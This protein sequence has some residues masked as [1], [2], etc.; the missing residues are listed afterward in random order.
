MSKL[1]A[2]SPEVK[3]AIL[4]V[5]ARWSSLSGWRA[6]DEEKQR[7]LI[8]ALRRYCDSA[9]DIL[10]CL[11]YFYGASQ[12][13]PTPNEIREAK[14]ERKWGMVGA[15][16]LAKL[17]A[18]ACKSC[19]E[20]EGSGKRFG[21]RTVPVP[22]LYASPHE[23]EALGPPIK[24]VDDVTADDFAIAGDSRTMQISVVE[25]CGCPY[26]RELA[27]SVK[28]HAAWVDRPQPVKGLAPV[29]EEDF[30]IPE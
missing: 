28:L 21:Y 4:Q 10:A 18:D 23:A 30:E 26:G 17:K 16:H 6:D 5:E 14:A 27:K 11:D 24:T 1:L 15:D 19:T 13:V 29:T 9:E 7:G 12:W 3:A 25:F 20:C 8:E 2:L 22:P